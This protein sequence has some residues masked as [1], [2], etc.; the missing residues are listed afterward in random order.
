M[1]TSFKEAE[2]RMADETGAL[3][4]ADLLR[5]TAIFREL[6]NDQLD[7][8]WSR[9]KVHNL[10]RGEVLV[11]QGTARRTPSTSWCPAASRSGSRGRTTP[12]NEI[13][14]GEPIGET[15]FFSGAPRN[16]TIVA[17]RDSVVLEL[18]RASFDSVAEKVPAIHQ[19]LLRALARR[20]AEGS[21]AARRND[22]APPRAPS[23]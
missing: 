18:D 1:P 9:A 10:L 3:N 16:A 2:F 15:G 17:A 7:E 12:I 13:G 14:V 23:R 4:A 22:A 11:R 8:I 6:S 5:S 19:T 20:L 21:H